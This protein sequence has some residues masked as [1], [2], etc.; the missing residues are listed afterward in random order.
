MFLSNFCNQIYDHIIKK[1]WDY[2]YTLWSHVLLKSDQSPKTLVLKKT[3]VKFMIPNI[4]M[5][6]VLS[7]TSALF[8][9]NNF[10]SIAAWSYPKG[11]R[12]FGSGTWAYSWHDPG[13][14]LFG[15]MI[16]FLYH[17]WPIFDQLLHP[18]CLIP[19]HYQAWAW[20]PKP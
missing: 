10:F 16:L 19:L 7:K 20:P 15:S 14:S 6:I 18:L 5:V 17:I 3:V 4:T 11:N 12:I 9:H 8:C 13:F 1:N 2:M